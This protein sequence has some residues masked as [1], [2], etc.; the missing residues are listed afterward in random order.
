MTPDSSTG[1]T[2]RLT[3]VWRV[4]W[5]AVTICIVQGAVCGLAVLPVMLL[6]SRLIGWQGPDPATR[7]LVYSLMVAPSYVL[8]AVFLMGLSPLATKLTGWRTPPRADMRIADLGWPLLD[9]VRYMVAIHIVRFFAGTLFRGSPLWTAYL[10]L[11]GARLGRRVYVNSLAVSDHSQLT[12]G[13]D[14][15]IGSDVHVSGH[16]VEGGLVKTAPVRLGDRVTIGLGT[17]VNIDVEA[18]PN[19]QIGALSLVP[20]H[21]RLD[22][23]AVYVGI[24]VARLT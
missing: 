10:R 23:G 15:V 9:W 4:A 22:G 20:K 14:V 24:P 5:T 6:W 7:L 13:D 17:V 11:N 16:T 12:F 3:V 21:S 2:N 8:F 19:C 18:G 1:R